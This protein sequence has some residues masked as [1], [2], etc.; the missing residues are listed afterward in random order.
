VKTPFLAILLCLFAYGAAQAQT[1]EVGLFGGLDRVSHAPLGSASA[2]APEPGDTSLHSTYSEGVW[3]TYNTNG[4]YG[5]EISF[6]DS[7]VTVSAILRATIN[8]VTVAETAQDRVWVPQINYNFL[9]Y[10]MPKGE[11]FRPFVTGG[12]QAE[13]YHEPNIL[14]WTSGHTRHYGLNW[15]GG[16][17]IKLFPHALARI[18]LR[19]YVGGKPY[20]L[21]LF[22]GGVLHTYEATA[23]IGVTF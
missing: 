11:R 14:N 22:P 18:D 19:D 15:G 8:G 9:I 5:H 21:P 2:T 17:K 16:V 20:S 3:L 12:A 4:Y 23:G 6:M 13:Q 10:F 1:Y 7:P